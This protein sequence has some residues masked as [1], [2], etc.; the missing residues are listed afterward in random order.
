[1]NKKGFTLVELLSTIII[2][3]LIVSITFVSI[4]RISEFAKER[5]RANVIKRIETAASKYAFDTMKEVVFVE[6][7]IKNGYLNG[8][9]DTDVIINPVD[10]SPLNCY[11]VTMERTDNYYTAKFTGEKYT[12]E[13]SNN[14][15]N[16]ALNIAYNKITIEVSK[17]GVT[18]NSNDWLSG[19]LTLTAKL[20]D[21]TVSCSG[22]NTCKWTS[23]NGLTQNDS[24]QIS[25]PANDESTTRYTFSYTNS[26]NKQYVT[27][28]D[29]KA[30]NI[31]PEV[32]SC[33]YNQNNT[34]TVS[35]KEKGSG[36]NAYCLNKST[37]ST[38][39][40]WTTISNNSFITGTDTDNF[41]IHVKDNAN[42]IG[43]K[44]LS[45]CNN[46]SI[47]YGDINLDGD[48]DVFDSSL[49][50]TYY[51]NKLNQLSRQAFFNAD[52]DASGEIDAF[53]MQKISNFDNYNMPYEP[54]T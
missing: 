24:A 1:M 4:G 15:D 51:P 26:E 39:C 9:K 10:N 49:F 23:S 21:N 44:I 40:S 19:Q 27:Y 37:S 3:A 38:G 48:V 29:L 7:L 52:V 20:N 6:E 8:E 25:I 50:L 34:W 35:L 31:G 43:Y 32:T 36:V 13:N 12:L 5:H 11:I 54:A 45:K 53:D 16:N 14:C 30:D 41:Y 18:Q 22:A 33:T 28:F 47:A 46:I 42:N 17:N 2:L